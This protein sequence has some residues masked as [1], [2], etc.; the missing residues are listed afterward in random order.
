MACES[1]CHSGV[2]DLSSHFVVVAT[3]PYLNLDTFL[4]FSLLK[5]KHLYCVYL[6][7]GELSLFSCMPF[8]VILFC[9]DNFDACWVSVRFCY[10]IIIYCLIEIIRVLSS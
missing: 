9:P 6:L 4:H 2:E 3:L 1:D 8:Q 5:G 7:R 10:D